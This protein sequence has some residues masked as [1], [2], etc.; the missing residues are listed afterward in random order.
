MDN[1]GASAQDVFLDGTIIHALLCT[2]GE[3]W[4]ESSL[5]LDFFVMADGGNFV[6]RK[7]HESILLSCSCF[8]LQKF[9]LH[10]LCLGPD[11]TIRRLTSTITGRTNVALSILITRTPTALLV[12]SAST[13]PKEYSFMR[14][15]HTTMGGGLPIRLISLSVS[16]ITEE[17]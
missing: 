9:V 2:K 7:P 16:L 1:F 4:T 6:F 15:L 8:S 17:S 14:S 13:L 12:M 3:V 5:N 10:V 11:G